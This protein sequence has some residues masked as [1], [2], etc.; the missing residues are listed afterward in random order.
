MDSDAEAAQEL[1]RMLDLRFDTGS[2][3]TGCSTRCRREQQRR[4]GR[5]EARTVLG[6]HI[7]REPDQTRS[8][9]MDKPVPHVD[10]GTRCAHRREVTVDQ[11]FGERV[12]TR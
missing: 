4:N 5:A 8:S 7:E 6:R 12:P 1:D 11:P 3:D 9:R 10:L 2:R